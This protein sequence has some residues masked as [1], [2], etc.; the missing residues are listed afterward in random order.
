MRDYPAEFDQR[1]VLSFGAELPPMYEQYI[2]WAEDGKV[3]IRRRRSE[4][5]VTLIENHEATDDYDADCEKLRKAAPALVASMEKKLL[6]VTMTDK[7]MSGWGHATGKIVK[8]IVACDTIGQVDQIM[9]AA[10]ARSEM[11]RIKSHNKKPVYP[12]RT[13]VTIERHYDQ[14]SGPW[15]E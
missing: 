3:F 1:L 4:N 11:M 5:E 7:F 2:F 6:Y 15:K 12:P 10:R 8:Y 13:H 14:L 9:K